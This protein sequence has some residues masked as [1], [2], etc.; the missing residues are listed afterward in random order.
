[1]TEDPSPDPSAIQSVLS[2]TTVEAQRI[3]LN[4]FV[5]CATIG[6]TEEER[7]RPQRIV[8]DLTLEM[9]ARP[10]ERDSVS[11]VLSYGLVVRELRCL[12]ADSRYALLETLA[13][14]LAAAFFAFAQVRATQIRV[15]K[16]DRYD[17][18]KAIGIEICRTR[19]AP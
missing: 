4:E 5:C 10:P 9:D 13:D 2:D 14:S 6:V 7:A 15:Q 17:E 18:I 3:V 8:I 19:A 11:E 16:L 1:M 12:C